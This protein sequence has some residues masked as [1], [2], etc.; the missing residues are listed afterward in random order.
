MKKSFCF[1]LTPLEVEG[2]LPFEVI[3]GHFIQRADAEQIGLIKQKLTPYFEPFFS[4]QYEFDWVPQADGGS[5]VTKRQ[6]KQELWRYWVITFPGSNQEFGKLNMAASLLREQIELGFAFQFFD[7]PIGATSFTWSAD[8]LSSF[9]RSIEARQNDV[10]NISTAC[11]K[12]MSE[13]HAAL[14]AAESAHPRIYRA[15]HQFHYLKSLPR[16]SSMLIVGYFSIIEAL[17]AHKPRLQESLDSINHQLQSKL[18]LLSKKFQRRVDYS[19]HFGKLN[20]E[21]IWKRLYAYRS[22]IAHDPLVEVD[23]EFKELGGQTKI[24]SF[25]SEVVKLLLLFGLEDPEFLADLKNC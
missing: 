14:K 7:E 6:L 19:A 20:E 18:I 10:S 17:I 5:G 25:L 2:D 12:E 3:P 8:F 9:F 22:A 1:I 21:R 13:N 24:R 23:T 15:V 11:L 16:Q 4:P